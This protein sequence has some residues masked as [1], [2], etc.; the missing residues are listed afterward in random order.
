MRR[1]LNL[2]VSRSTQTRPLHRDGLAARGPP[3]GTK[4]H[5]SLQPSFVSQEIEQDRM[6]EDKPRTTTQRSVSDIDFLR[7]NDKIDETDF[8]MV[9]TREQPF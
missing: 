8:C 1:P 5:F 4:C 6:R 9:R 7:Q 3:F 2:A